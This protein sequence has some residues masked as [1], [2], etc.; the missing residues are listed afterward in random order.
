[1]RKGTVDSLK[2]GV[3][4]SFNFI[5][6]GIFGTIIG[7]MLIPLDLYR[8]PKAA[9][10]SKKGED[11]NYAKISGTVTMLTGVWRIVAGSITLTCTV[12]LIPPREIRQAIAKID[13]NG[14]KLRPDPCR[15]EG[16][17][18]IYDENRRRRLLTINNNTTNLSIHDNNN[19][20]IIFNNSEIGVMKTR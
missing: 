12:S 5:G 7:A 20:V 17:H 16:K 9:L 3:S 15:S 11:V 19:T 2:E 14:S 6:N 8:L 13:K 10:D 4:D 18:T 1:M